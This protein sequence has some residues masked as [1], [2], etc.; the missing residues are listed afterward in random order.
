MDIKYE[1]Q[2]CKRDLK[3]M[4]PDFEKHGRIL[5]IRPCDVNNDWPE[6]RTWVG[7]GLPLETTIPNLFNVGDACLAPELNGTSGAVESGYRVAEII[8]G[9]TGLT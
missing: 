2:Q 1:A 8:R 4:F 3:E 5:Q 6:G 7:Y 9:N